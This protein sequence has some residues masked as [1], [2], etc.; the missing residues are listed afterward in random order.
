MADDK[1]QLTDHYEYRL[2][3]RNEILHMLAHR[4]YQA[5]NLINKAIDTIIA[6]AKDKWQTIF[7]GEQ[8]STI[9]TAINEFTTTGLNNSLS[10]IGL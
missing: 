1:K 7:D 9:K 4:L 3:W 2:K 6:F 5:S 10:V 8:A